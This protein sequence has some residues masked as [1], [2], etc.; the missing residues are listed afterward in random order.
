MSISLKT[1]KMLWGRS[2]N[3][4]AFPGCKKELV[5]DISETDDISVVGE[6][7]HIVAREEDGPRGNSTLNQEQRNKYT[8]LIL[9]CS[10]HHKVIDDHP[11]N[12]PV[13]KLKTIKQT[14]ELLIR[15]NN[16]IDN[17]RQKDDEL[18][19]TYVDELARLCNLNNFKG[20]T[21]FLIGGADPSISIKQYE[22]LSELTNYIL[23]R[24]WPKRYIEL[25]DSII[26]LNII[27]NDFLKVF[28]KYSEESEKNFSTR[29]FYKT[30]DWNQEKYHKLLTKFNYHVS[31]INDLVFEFTRALNFIFDNIRRFVLSSY[32][33]KEGLLLLVAGPFM[34]FTWKTY[35]TEYKIEERASRPYPGLK[36]FMEIRN[37]R[38]IVWGEG[39]SNDYFPPRFDK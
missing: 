29:K 22:N 9:L 34:D 37:N 6:E 39:V 19:A 36:K 25:E 32:R 8:N 35:R 28:D 16:Q 23:S 24:V 11:E 27:L 26:N 17:D 20:W 38:D 12:Y 1:H 15:Q 21:S 3:I 2:G 33:I 31:L 10:I 7:A 14:H 13:E 30:D 18:Y 4:C 5:M